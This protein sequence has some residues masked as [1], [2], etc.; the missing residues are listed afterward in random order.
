MDDSNVPLLIA[1]LL[2]LLLVLLFTVPCAKY[3]SGPSK[4]RLKSE[5]Y[6]D[7]DGRA[8]EKSTAEYNPRLAKTLL[9]GL[10]ILGFFV[11]LSLAVLSTAGPRTNIPCIATW[12][13]VAQW[14]YL[15]LPRHV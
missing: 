7:I 3:P 2:S 15:A 4:P 12:M 6:E 5:I 11:A 1:A 14:V 9:A 13:Q 10:T 8:T